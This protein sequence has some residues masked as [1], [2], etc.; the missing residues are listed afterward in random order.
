MTPPAGED[1]APVIAL[2]D[3]L[4]MIIVVATG[5]MAATFF[6]PASASSLQETMTGA[7]PRVYWYLGRSS[8]FV[9][10]GWLWLSMILGL[11]MTN[12]LARM[13]RGGPSVHELHQFASL[14]ALVFAVFHAFILMGSRFLHYSL[15]DVL[16]PFHSDAYRTTWV[17]LGQLALYGLAM[18]GLS[19]Y[20]R[21]RISQPVWRLIHYLSFAV[22]IFVVGHGFLAGTDSASGVALG[23]YVL[24]VVSVALMLLVRIGRSVKLKLNR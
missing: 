4:L 7:K 8:A 14:T 11:M 12:K 10:M 23:F 18:V 20:I 9:A 13:W 1:M 5:A 17:G 2:H 24:S 19:F 15:L 3:W 6:I 16:M 22:F 21:R